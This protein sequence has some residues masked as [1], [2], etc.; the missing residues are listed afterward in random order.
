LQQFYAQ[1]TPAEQA[2]AMQIKQ[3]NGQ[4]YGDAF[5]SMGNKSRRSTAEVA[6]IKAGLSQAADFNQPYT[7]PD[8]KSGYLPALNDLQDRTHKAMANAY[9]AAGNLDAIPDNLK[10]DQNGQPLVD[11]TFRPG[12]QFAGAGGAWL[13]NP[14]PKQGQGQPGSPATI[15]SPGDIAKLAK[16]TP[17]VIPSGPNQGKIGYAQ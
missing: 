13:N 15:Q 9:G 4:I 5:S 17:F 2:V 14:P 7:S 3:L 12:G 8:G 16:G 10:W 6:G 1:L 11:Q